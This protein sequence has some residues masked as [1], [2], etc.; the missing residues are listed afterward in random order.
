MCGELLG[1]SAQSRS[2]VVMW[3]AHT[4][5]ANRREQEVVGQ[6]LQRVRLCVVAQAVHLHAALVVNVHVPAGSQPQG[7][8]S[9]AMVFIDRA[10]KC[11]QGHGSLM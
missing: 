6:E 4:W 2:L 3:P 5:V 1:A 9:Q 7:L 10:L 11:K 8:L